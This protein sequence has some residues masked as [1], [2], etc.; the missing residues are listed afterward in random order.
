MD[1]SRSSL[2]TISLSLVLAIGCVCQE[3]PKL[4]DRTKTFGRSVNPKTK[5]DTRSGTPADA[6]E[7][8]DPELIRV[9]TDLVVSDVLVVNQKGN[10]IVGLKKD[11]FVIIENGV[12]KKVDYFASGSGEPVPRSI[13]LIFDYSGS[14]YGF[15]DE[16]VAAAKVLIDKLG[17]LDRMAIVTDDL[18]LLVDFTNDKRLLKG[19]L[20]D[21][22]AKALRGS[23]GKSIQLSALVATLQELFDEEDVRP[24]IIMQSDGDEF[25]WLKP[26]PSRTYTVPL[27]TTSS[28]SC[29]GLCKRASFDDIYRLLERS[30]ATFYAIVPGYNLITLPPDKRQ[31]KYEAQMKRRAAE[32]MRIFRTTSH[33]S[34]RVNLK[35][36]MGAAFDAQ[37]GLRE[38][39]LMSGGYIDF[40]EEPTDANN[41][42]STLFD[43]ISNR[44]SL[45]YYPAE[46]DK[47]DSWR[48]MMVS[49]RGHPEYKIVG[50]K[51]FFLPGQ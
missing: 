47:R 37:S 16:S 50:R 40:I 1:I 4:R 10:L 48:T 29:Y 6:I 34:S 3:P 5:T 46:T 8:V 33:W 24:I 44:Y 43:T 11:D 30:R 35:K 23:D 14:I 49:V 15:L 25:G 36:F 13:V 7:S 21:I 51:R 2:T 22:H 18:E 28:P 41:V 12:E 45:G 38:L 19:K 26:V 9:R 32:E 20:D 39:S 42:Y 27:T 17:S 31:S